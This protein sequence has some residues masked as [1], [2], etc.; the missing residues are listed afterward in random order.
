MMPMNRKTF[1][2]A[3]AITGLLLSLIGMQ[4]AGVAKAEPRTIVVPTDYPTIQAAINAAVNGDTVQIKKGIYVE[5]PQV[6]RSISLVGE[7]R[8]TTIIEG[9]VTINQSNAAIVGFTI[10][11]TSGV[12]TFA[13][14]LYSTASYCSISGNRIRENDNGVRIIFSP[15]NNIT[16]NIIEYNTYNSVKLS[17]GNAQGANYNKIQGNIISNSMGGIEL[18]NDC[19]NNSITGNEISQCSDFGVNIVFA[20]SNVFSENNITNSGCGIRNSGNM[21]AFLLNNFIDNTQQANNEYFEFP[22]GKWRISV[23]TWNENYWSDYNGTDAN[24]DGIGDTPYVIDANNKDNYPLMRAVNIS[25]VSP[26]PSPSLPQPTPTL[27]YPPSPSPSP[28]VPEF[29]SWIFLPLTMV[30]AL[31]LVYFVRRK[32]P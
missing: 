27:P 32:K 8:D 9:Q 15:N 4:C 19:S 14:D 24:A 5:N 21:N 20:G 16:G 6:N 18:T 13:V 17:G 29:P 10:Q 25:V 11:H 22:T 31:V 30:I 7:D 12:T 1:M 26:S 23:G 2:A 3:L 28:S